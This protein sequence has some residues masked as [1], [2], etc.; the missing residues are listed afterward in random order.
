MGDNKEKEYIMYKITCNTDE[1]LIY[2]GSTTNF[3][4]R[5][6]A[7]KTCS[8]NEKT[9]QYNFNIY[10]TIRN[11]GG[12]SNW[13]MQPIEIFFTNNKTKAKIRENQLMETFKS[14]L[15]CVKAYTSK[16]EKY[17]NMKQYY[18]NNREIINSRKSNTFV[19]CDCG[20]ELRKDKLT[21]H[22]TT[23]K[24][25]KYLCGLVKEEEK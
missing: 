4:V 1:N 20:A 7:H 16:E 3:R 5:K 19:E 22:K 2:I 21:R 12:W 8:N 13:N 6:N 23:N 14:N 17:D 24:H 11:N 18:L 10:K 9:K 25:Q 15:N